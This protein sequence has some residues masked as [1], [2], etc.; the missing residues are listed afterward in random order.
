MCDSQILKYYYLT[1]YRKSLLTWK[2]TL[3]SLHIPTSAHKHCKFLWEVLGKEFQLLPTLLRNQ[4]LMIA[5]KSIGCILWHNEIWHCIASKG[6]VSYFPPTGLAPVLPGEF[7]E[8]M[9]WTRVYST[10]SALSSG[11]SLSP[12]FQGGKSREPQFGFGSKLLSSCNSY[13]WFP[14]GCCAHQ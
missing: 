2:E 3:P 12:G 7:N 5:K 10:K 1:L 9:C 8:T 11:K 14:G 6:E 4:W 13:P